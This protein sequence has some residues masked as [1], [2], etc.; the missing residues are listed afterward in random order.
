M[1]MFNWEDLIEFIHDQRM[2]IPVV[3]KEFS[4]VKVGDE[5]LPLERVLA[6]RLA[7]DDDLHA[8]AAT[9]PT[10]DGLSD[11]IGHLLSNGAKRDVLAQRL[12]TT[13]KSLLRELTAD[14]LHP[15]LLKIAGIKDFKL[16]LS[17]SPDGLLPLAIKFANGGEGPLVIQDTCSRKYDLPDEW[18]RSGPIVYQLFGQVNASAEFALTEDDM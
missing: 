8:K 18:L 17:T 14:R 16:W 3:G 15:S 9:C 4:I 12:Y 11:L 2:V 1:S 13:H 10:V 5:W 7:L 6:Q